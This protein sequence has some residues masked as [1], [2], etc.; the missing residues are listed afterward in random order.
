MSK[1]LIIRHYRPQDIRACLQLNKE[2]GIAP[3]SLENLSQKLNKPGYPATE[4]VFVAE[5]GGAVTGY[6]SL[7][8]ELGIGRVVL[9]YLVHP[10]YSTG[11][12]LKKLIDHA[13]ERATEL[14]ANVVHLSIPSAEPVTAELLLSLEF[15]ATRRFHE[16]MLDLSEVSLE[17]TSRPNSMCRYLEPG[18]EERLAQI[19]NRCFA[20]TWGYHPNTVEEIIWHMSFKNSSPD[21][22]ILAWDKSKLIGYCWTEKKCDKDLSTGKNSGRIY[23]LGVSPDYRN[24]GVG[25]KLLLSALTRLKSMG[26]EIVHMTVDSQ[27]TA[28]VSLY[29]SLGFKIREDT[30]WYEKIIE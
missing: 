17:A 28:A 11:F 21:D 9:D 5:M 2:F 13:V 22:I 23:M 10:K 24:R 6:I 18:E 29:S 1:N 16:L 4:N 14:E 8:P 27:N 12:V 19:Q 15:R 3:A 30:L 20:G 7:T 26:R 25:R